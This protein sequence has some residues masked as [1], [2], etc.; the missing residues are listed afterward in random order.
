[1]ALMH[2][3]T[4]NLFHKGYEFFDPGNECPDYIYRICYDLIR[5]GDMEALKRAYEF[6]NRLFGR[7]EYREA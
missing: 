5:T 6:A 7:K 4:E 3:Y 2:L 1:M